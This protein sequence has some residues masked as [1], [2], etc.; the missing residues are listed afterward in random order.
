MEK[1]VFSLSLSL[2]LSFHAHYKYFLQIEVILVHVQVLQAL[3]SKVNRVTSNTERL[4]FLGLETESQV[5]K[6]W[7]QSVTRFTEEGSNV[8]VT[9]ARDFAISLAHIYTGL[10]VKL[11]L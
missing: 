5:I 3:V 9:A 6:N 4:Q 7:T 10:S 2:S 8:L 1:S 11:F